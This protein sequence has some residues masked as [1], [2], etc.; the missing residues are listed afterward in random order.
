MKNVNRFCLTLFAVMSVA[1]PA[2]AQ[3]A[4]DTATRPANS[5]FPAGTFGAVSFLQ[6]TAELHEQDG[7][8]AFDVTRGY[9]NIQA[10]L[11]DRV[12]IRFTPDV[13]PTTD[14]SLQSNLSLRLEYAS[15]EADATPGTTVMFG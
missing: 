13:R 8:N 7:Y 14:A 4:G 6:S 15:L 12:K 3:T 9:L 1:G 10:R 2:S 11:S 5:N